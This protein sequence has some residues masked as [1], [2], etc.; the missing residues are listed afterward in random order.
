MKT[1]SDINVDNK[2]VLLRVDYNVPM[3]DDGAVADCSRI[4][5]TKPTI[6]YLRDHGA[7]V[8]LLAHFGRPQGQV[9][10]TDRLRP[11]ISAVSATL[12]VTVSYVDDCIG[13]KP[14]AAI[15]QLQPGD[16]VLLENVRFYPGEESNDPAFAKQLAELGEVYVNDAF[17]AAHRAH[18]STAGIAQYLPHAAGLLMQREVTELTTVLQHPIHP[19]VAIIGGAKI[20]TKIDLITNLL[21]KVDYVLLGG[22]LA[23]TVLLAQNHQIGKS[24]V[25]AELAAT[26]KDLLSNKL[27]VPVDVVVAKA[28][29]E[30]SPKRVV[31]LGAVAAD[32][33][34]VD[35]GPDT[36]RVYED[37]IRQAKT[38]IWNGPMGVFELEAFAMGTYHIAKLV[39]DSEAYSILGGG[40]TVSAVKKVGLE[41]SINFISTGGGA[42][43]EF[44]EGK[45]L[46]GIV[47][48]D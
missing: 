34:I 36:V 4:I 41:Q 13:P 21:P 20:S 1:L 37:C 2:I 30:K 7:K 33:Y 42:M 28:V 18:A 31:S 23:N 9:H 8:V 43:L 16:V 27:K 46:P 35:I 47:A 22:A 15:S 11:I 48:L 29:A 44:L 3:T 38:I 14:K 45:I 25:E 6:Q 12:G 5:E 24:L 17:G 40:E 32:D 39:A 26:V 19:V 10:E